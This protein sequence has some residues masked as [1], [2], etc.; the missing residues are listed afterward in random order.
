MSV[1]SVM[2]LCST[3]FLLLRRYLLLIDVLFMV[4]WPGSHQ[5]IMERYLYDWTSTISENR[6][7]LAVT[8]NG[9]LWLKIASNTMQRG[10]VS[11]SS[12]NQQSSFLHSLG[13]WNMIYMKQASIFCVMTPYFG[14]VSIF[15]SGDFS[16]ATPRDT[17]FSNRLLIYK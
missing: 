2:F 11:E 12:Q 3:V 10:V 5:L 13:P 1:R 9:R 17:G 15:W 8:G 16:S 14:W 7:I 4:C 6:F